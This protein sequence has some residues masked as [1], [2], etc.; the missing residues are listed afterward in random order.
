MSFTERRDAS[1]PA[2]LRA[3]ETG[4][5]FRAHGYRFANRPAQATARERLGAILQRRAF[6]YRGT[7]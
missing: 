3:A 7:A 1:P 6:A 4:V 2:R 5:L